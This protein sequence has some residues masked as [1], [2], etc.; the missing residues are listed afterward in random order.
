MPDPEFIHPGWW[1]IVFLL[2]AYSKWIAA[3]IIIAI[4][5]L[6]AVFVLKRKMNTKYI[7]ITILI[8]LGAVAVM[9]RDN[10]MSLFSKSPNYEIVETRSFSCPGLEGFTFEY[11][12]FKGWEV[13]E[14]KN[15]NINECSI[16]LEN[17]KNAQIKVS[18]DQ[19]HVAIQENPHGIRYEKITEDKYFFNLASFSVNIELISV[20]ENYGFSKNEFWKQ[21]VESF[22]VMR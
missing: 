16:S 11:P 14:M 22:R 18:K 6:V 20:N 2:I 5:S 10:L 7:L 15:T 19:P 4:L 9:Y 13:K 3:I 12:V 1:A 17:G 8:A 21:V